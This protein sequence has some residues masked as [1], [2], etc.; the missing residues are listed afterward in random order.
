I[1]SLVNSILILSITGVEPFL[2]NLLNFN[3]SLGFLQSELSFYFIITLI[4]GLTFVIYAKKYS[5]F[6][7]TKPKII[8][9][10]LIYLI[11][12]GYV[13]FYF[14]IVTFYKILK[15]DIKW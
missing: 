6:K 11:V 4:I 14:W 10:Y 7:K 15:K 2:S 5:I 3:F 1:F 12:S 9:Q 8:L 13:Y